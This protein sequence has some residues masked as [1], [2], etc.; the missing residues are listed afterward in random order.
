MDQSGERYQEISEERYREDYYDDSG[1]RRALNFA[2]AIVGVV[3]VCFYVMVFY[4]ML[5]DAYKTHQENARR[6]VAAPCVDCRPAN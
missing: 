3:V 5:S 1:V 6:R 4:T 2:G